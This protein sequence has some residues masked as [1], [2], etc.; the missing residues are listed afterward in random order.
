MKINKQGKSDFCRISLRN[1]GILLVKTNAL[2]SHT[3]NY[4]QMGRLRRPAYQYCS[5]NIETQANSYA[6]HCCHHQ[7][8]RST[9]NS[10]S[11]HSLYCNYTGMTNIRKQC[12]K[13]SM[14]TTALAG[15]FRITKA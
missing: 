11:K 8:F 7:K 4:L 14:Y 15:Y 2:T 1:K 6:F 10:N 12:K 3:S 9:N 5:G 13:D